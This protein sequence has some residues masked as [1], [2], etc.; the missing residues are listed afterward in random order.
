M[1]A[2]PPAGGPLLCVFAVKLS[3]E[4]QSPL[5]GL[6]PARRAEGPASTCFLSD[7]SD[8]KHALG[9]CVQSCRSSD[10]KCVGTVWITLCLG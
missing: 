3:L 9:I 2:R 1:C 5:T 6:S 4:R 7:G 10:G 8:C